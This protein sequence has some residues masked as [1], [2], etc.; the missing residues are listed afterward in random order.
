M[1][2]LID[3]G[4]L[5]GFWPLNEPS[6]T[7]FFLNHSPARNAGPSGASYD[8]HVS[9]ADNI[10]TEEIRS[11]WPGT[12]SVSNSHSGTVY[13]GYMTQGYWKLG[14]DSSPYSRYLIL[15]N[16]NAEVR[17]QTLVPN[18]AQ[19]GFTVGIWVYPNSN[20]YLNYYTD[21]VVGTNGET[22]GAR[23]HSLI[24]QFQY[25][26]IAG[27]HI[28]ISGHMDQGAQYASVASNRQLTAYA[29]LE[30]TADNTA[31]TI[32]R[33]PIESG[34]FTHLAFSYRFVNGTNA[35][36]IVLYKDGRLAASGTPSFGASQSMTLN[37]TTLLAQ[38]LTIG[39]S[40]NGAAG[41]SDYNGTAGWNHLV[42]GAYFFRRVLNEGEILSLHQAGSL[43]PQPDTLLKTRE[44]TILDSSLLAHYSF[45][46][47]GLPDASKNHYPLIT[48]QDEGVST[49]YIVCPGP[50]NAGSILQKGTTVSDALVASSGLIN[51]ILTSR[52]WSIGMFAG[53]VNNNGRDG[54]MVLSWGITSAVTTSAVPT[55]GTS[56]F[57]FGI[58]ITEFGS[59][60]ANNHTRCSAYPLGNITDNVINIDGSNSGYFN[61]TISHYCIVYDDQTSGFAFYINGIM[62][63]SGTTIVS[64]TDHLTKV[65]GSGF[66]LMFTN[67]I[68]T[69][70]VDSTA[71][72]LH[73][74]GGGNLWAGPI[75]ILGRPLLPQE[76]RGLAV[77]GINTNALLRTRFDPRLMGYWSCSNY[78]LD[79]VIVPD[80]AKVWERTPGNLLRG[81][82]SIKW[83]IYKTASHRADQF[84]T[85]PTISA[86]SSFGNLG[87]T[88]GVFGVHG[89]SPGT[90]TQADADNVRS[91]IGN[92]TTRYK[93]VMEERDASYPQNFIGEY[94][95]AYTVTPSGNI[96]ST[97]L[98]LSADANKFE[99]N[100][101]LHTFGNM[102][103]NFSNLGESRS[104]LTTIDAV[105][106][107]G[108]SIVF[109][110][111]AGTLS[112]ANIFTAVSGVIPFGVPSNILLHS[113]FDNPYNTN[114]ETLGTTK[115]TI[116]L[117]INGTIVQSVSTTAILSKLWSDQLPDSADDWIL[118][119]GGEATDGAVT[120]TSIDDNGLG[121]IYLRNIFLM[122][123]MFGTNEVAALAASGI[124]A[125]TITGYT[126][127]Q[128]TT[129]VIITDS[130]L[131]GYWRFNGLDGNGSGTTN[132][133]GTPHLTP[134]IEN[135]NRA[136]GAV[137]S[138]RIVKFLP[139][140]L[141]N[142]DLGVR[143]SGLSFADVTATGTTYPPFAVS[144]VAF[145]SPENG[146]S[147]GF[148]LSKQVSTGASA[149]DVMMVYGVLPTNPITS[150]FNPNYSWAI[151]SDDDNNVKMT[152]SLGG[153]M[154]LNNAAVAAQS[155]QMS[156]GCYDNANLSAND[157]TTFEQF[158][159][160]AIAPGRKDF[161]S[162]YAW[163]YNAT[164]K[165]LTCYCN[166]IEVDARTIRAGISPFNGTS[167]LIPH[168]PTNPAAR[169]I[170]FLNHQN[171]TPWTFT[172]DSGL[173]DATSILTDVFYFSRSLT[174]AE[175]R[176]IAYNGIDDFHGSAVSGI[177]GGYISGSDIGSGLAG[178]HLQGL[179]YG[180][181]LIGGFYTGSTASSGCIGG[182]VSGVFFQGIGTIGGM[183]YATEIVSGVLGGFVYAKD[184]VSGILG[185]F[186][187]GGL[188]NS[189]QFDTS[190]TLQAIA[191]ENFDAQLE[192]AKTTTS[193]FDAKLIIFQN[194]IQPLVDIIIPNITVSGLKPPFNQYFIGVAS[195]QQ[196]KTITQTRWNFGDLT[197]TVSTSVSGAGFYPV[198]HMFTGSGF[199]IVKFE[200]ID[201]NGMH[202]SATRI[203]N[204]AS[205]ISPVIISL[206]GVP[207][208]GS[209]GLTVD[210]TTA[211]DI[212]PPGVSVSTQLLNFDDG[213]NT[214]SFS[215]THVY[216]EPGT[217]K[218]IWVVRDSRGV[219]W[220]DSLEAG[221]DFLR[222]GG[223]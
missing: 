68:S 94:I 47:V 21:V 199:Y 192:I 37:N 16:G 121:E 221:N 51:L 153:Q 75:T 208:S 71:K 119:F 107:S 115:L 35:D 122:H 177:T 219:I 154:Y 104:F 184:T 99:H 166:G 80:L 9:L 113:K 186:V 72:G 3:D 132:L 137:Q 103:H 58:A 27:W 49:N 204:A 28:G 215:P 197:P 155:G 22:E 171:T 125:P 66:P 168:A 100:S 210:F 84:G 211:V 150:T 152:M 159:F 96:P 174:Q 173:G 60:A 172:T 33:T 141:A 93:P 188:Q 64:L 198:Q 91:S 13:T 6:G 129:Q 209:S 8:F 205:G 222:N 216:N 105:R 118:Q 178:A 77:S 87:I 164:T 50:F 194:E 179:D 111:R 156:V 146:F 131:E 89:G 144:G 136:G 189:F 167:V 128:S 183:I 142:S 135:V 92:F 20:G 108:V 31:P 116:T 176:Y 185:G 217:Y 102:G 212:L 11:V 158:R 25:A 157:L 175:V 134:I 112:A 143:C 62:Q 17:A 223:V 214:I 213:Q 124:Q 79:D 67:G 200:A 123:G 117:W 73:A 4:S 193:D 88:S 19:S 98:G 170:T 70:L 23:A 74:G 36:A 81:D 187:L 5:I 82:G 15:G 138:S 7:P 40:D 195:G 55:Q 65:A 29:S 207:R 109:A 203:V 163:T 30:R 78:S 182:Y 59:A 114:G 120:F 46:S 63:G 24:G 39:G 126:S 61:S 45:A 151:L 26:Q 196:G 202:N 149:T 206:S 48:D 52:S 180:S 53:P 110:N 41:S 97:L 127:E 83:T 145:D 69:T 161:W 95:L 169:M 165:V 42:S 34:R 14:T 130:A 76:V 147:V 38:P 106:G 18:V 133:A 86:L 101:T 32:L 140:P 1:V 90:A 201:S 85:R 2:N 139:G 12:A 162:H 44:V 181:G 56:P 54:N 43:Q 160:G 190:F 218:P 220:C 148:W 10:N 191:A 57:T